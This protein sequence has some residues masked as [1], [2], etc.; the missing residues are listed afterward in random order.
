MSMKKQLELVHKA[1]EERFRE[2]YSPTLRILILEGKKEQWAEK[3]EPRVVEAL[4]R[5]DPLIPF[6]DFVAQVHAALGLRVGYIEELDSDEW[7][8][9]SRIYRGPGLL[10]W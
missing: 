3:G 4:E 1:M 2:G 5:I 6:P 10:L 7:E 8:T 9:P